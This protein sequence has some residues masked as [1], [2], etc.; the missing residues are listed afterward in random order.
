MAFDG[1]VTKT[2]INELNKVIIGAKI[3]KIFEPTK[4]NIILGLYNKGKNYSLNI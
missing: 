4:S 2:I 1:L 3:N